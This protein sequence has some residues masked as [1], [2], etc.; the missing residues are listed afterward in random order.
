MKRP[1]PPALENV[2][3]GPPPTTEQLEAIRKY[4]ERR[5]RGERGGIPH[6]EARRRLEELVR[7]RAGRAD[8]D[9]SVAGRRPR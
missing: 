8:V 4:E 3:V 5:A 9:R 2:P 1:L 6:D 7:S